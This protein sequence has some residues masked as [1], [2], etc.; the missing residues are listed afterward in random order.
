M[1]ASL[2]VTSAPP[3]TSPAPPPPPTRMAMCWGLDHVHTVLTP[4]LRGAET[5]RGSVT[6]PRTHSLCRTV[7]VQICPALKPASRGRGHRG[8]VHE[9]CWKALPPTASQKS[10]HSP[11][12]PGGLSHSR[13]AWSPSAPRR[14]LGRVSDGHSHKRDPCLTTITHPRPTATRTGCI[15]K[16]R[17]TVGTQLANSCRR[18]AFSS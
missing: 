8:S 18:S 15:F 6:R 11:A 9:P 7:H 16:D 2:P 4:T 1:G 17:K 5:H 14:G 13:R 3:P 12:A 10:T